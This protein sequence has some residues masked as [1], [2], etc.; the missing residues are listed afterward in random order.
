MTAIKTSKL[1]VN[2]KVF[3]NSWQGLKSRQGLRRVGKNC[4]PEM[5]KMSM[6]ENKRDKV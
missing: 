1:D 2:R 6:G 5:R 3:E 4:G